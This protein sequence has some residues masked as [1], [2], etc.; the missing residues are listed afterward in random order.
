MEFLV[1]R[2]LKDYLALRV[3]LALR[4]GKEDTVYRVILAQRDAEVLK[5]TVVREELVDQG[6]MGHLEVKDKRETEVHQDH[7]ENEDQEQGD[8]QALLAYQ[9]KWDHQVQRG[10]G[11]RLAHLVH[12]VQLTS[13]R[14]HQDQKVPKVKWV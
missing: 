11:D 8:L 2:A 7:L 1:L 10:I 5:E 6:H 12:L 3:H 9:V 14:V 13:V 4:V